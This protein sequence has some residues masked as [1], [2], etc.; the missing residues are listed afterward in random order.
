MDV[1]LRDE[2][3]HVRIGNRWFEHVCA[4]RGLEPQASYAALFAAHH[5]QPLRGPFNLAA[6]RAA[7]FSEAELHA[8]QAQGS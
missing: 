1:I 3:G 6:R 5:P 4:Q 2:V 7:G 8:L